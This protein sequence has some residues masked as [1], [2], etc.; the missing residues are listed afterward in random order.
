MKNDIQFSG[1]Y[2]P[3]WKDIVILIGACKSREIMTSVTLE[4]AMI[5]IVCTDDDQT[6]RMI[7]P[8]Q[9]THFGQTAI[10]ADQAFIHITETLI[11]KER[12]KRFLFIHDGAY[13]KCDL[14]FQFICLSVYMCMFV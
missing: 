13:G 11:R 12:W 7:T 9:L 8:V 3:I 2:S 4:L 5:L 10:R 14:H 1:C 6:Y